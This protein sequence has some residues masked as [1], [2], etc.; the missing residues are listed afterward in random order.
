MDT[1]KRTKL[2]QLVT[3]WHRGTVAVASHLKTLGITPE[4]LYTYKHSH[5]IEALGQGAYKLSGDTVEW[6]GAVYALQTQLALPVHVG[7]KTALHL[8][9]YAH[10]L[11]ETLTQVFLYG[12]PGQKLPAWFK[13]YP[14]TPPI[15]FTAT[16]LFPEDCCIGFSEFQ[17]KEFSIRISSPERAA[18]E[19]FYHVP[20]QVGF[21]EA[22]LIA[23]NLI[24][25]RPAILQP[26]LEA[27]TNIKVKRL[28]LYVA[29]HHQHPWLEQIQTSRMTLGTGKRVL[30]K[31]G[32]LDPQ[33][34]I[35]VP[36]KIM[37]PM[38]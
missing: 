10:Y 35:T 9:G 30:V 3:T 15:L 11:S 38:C 24:N 32:V 6:P 33:Y 37:E 17:D 4:L 7:G 27:C 28:F 14:W 13:N 23:E 29:D 21:D 1:G 2:H 5:W 20:K 12:T 25:L 26:L 8:K 31:H 22:L 18:L 36:P 16:G 19:M 34:Q